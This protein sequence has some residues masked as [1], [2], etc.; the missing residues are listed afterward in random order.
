M[1]VFANKC[2]LLLC[3]IQGAAKPAGPSAIRRG[4]CLRLPDAH[5]SDD[6]IT[7]FNGSAML[8]Q[9]IVVDADGI[10]A[11][12]AVGSVTLEMLVA[13]AAAD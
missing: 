2:K 7:A 13:E 4:H 12:N 1:Q 5:V 10:I 6:V 3:S 9:T 11:Y 8:P